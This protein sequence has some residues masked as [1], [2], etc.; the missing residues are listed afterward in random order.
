MSADAPDAT[1]TP[2]TPAGSEDDDARALRRLTAFVALLAVAL[3]PGVIWLT[4]LPGPTATPGVNQITV[5]GL[6]AVLFAIT[7]LVTIDIELRH[8]SVNLSFSWVPLLVGLTFLAPWVVLAMKLVATVFVLVIVH[9]Q[10][11]F[12]FAVNL[13]AA[14]AEV[15]L[16]TLVLHL[17]PDA[18]GPARWGVLLLAA[19]VADLAVGFLVAT[20]ISIF[21]GRWETASTRSI[22]QGIPF[23]VLGVAYAALLTALIAAQQPE[24][25]LAVLIGALIVALL[26]AHTN[27]TTRHR[28]LRLLDDFTRALGRAATEG[29]VTAVLLRET[30]EVLHADGAFLVIRDGDEVTRLDISDGYALPR[31][32]GDL[33]RILLRN[34]T[35]EVRLFHESGPVAE[36]LD[37]AG[38]TEA[39]AAR[40]ATDD[41]D[42]LAL[43]VLERS[44]S[45]R[46]F[47]D[48]D[49]SLFQTL[50]VHAGLALQNMDLVH[51]LRDEVASTEHTATHDALTEL[52]NRVMFQRVVAE[53]VDAGREL[54]VLLLDLDRFKEVNDTLGHQN[55]DLLLVEV[56]N[57][58]QGAIDA[59]DVVARLGG[60]EF[61]IVLPDLPNRDPAE[62][63]A[64]RI[65]EELARPFVLANVS[66]DIGASIGI[67]GSR[68]IATDAAALL[69]ESDVAMYCA[70][71][72][73]TGVEVYASDRDHYSPQRLALAGRLRHAIEAAELAMAFQPQMDLATGRVYG[74]E[75]LV[76]WPQPNGRQIPPDDFIYM[77]EH[78]GLIRSLSQLVLRLTIAQ[79]ATWRARGIELQVSANL[80]AP[81]LS[82]PDLVDQIGALLEEHDLPA[83][84]LTVEVTESAVMANPVRCLAAL[85]QLRDLGMGVSIDDFGTGH[86]SLAY[87]TSLPATEL[88]IDRSFVD[89]MATDQAAATLVGAIVDLGRNL[90]LDV[91]AEGVE[92]QHATDQLLAMG[93]RHGQGYFFGRPMFADQFDAWLE[94]HGGPAAPPIRTLS[95]TPLRL[96]PIPLLR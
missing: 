79:A 19:I 68:G 91:I 81:N 38:P 20:A 16:V 71:A 43:V 89:A 33:E 94:L 54:S 61:A 53:L 60:D 15:Q 70:K 63:V 56:G 58:I 51:R 23:T 86:S 84:L 10:P 87:L 88:K 40:L 64:R 59:D 5:I 6:L 49:L 3:T 69:R 83:H 22:L 74:A 96:T 11:V 77:A 57:R 52:P 55:G 27:L 41:H 67:A 50:A 13:C 66:V 21:E 31:P 12:K 48:D 29:N 4:G 46:T 35:D 90:D 25:A 24:A 17:A 28:Q 44:G 72:D 47:D 93:C 92:T 62:A 32:A 75:A 7:E 26:R 18:H 2:P 95:R 34:L 9:R 85:Q 39:M 78:T 30:A 36:H 80:S 82:E 37:D 76:R 8:E 45:L 65:I 14:I 1:A 42:D 73:K